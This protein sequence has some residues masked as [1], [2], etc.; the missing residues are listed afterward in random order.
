M[1][2]IPPLAT[3]SGAAAARN[4]RKE[5]ATGF[6]NHYGLINLANEISPTVR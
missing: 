1:A 2:C 3:E 6:R 4:G 5:I